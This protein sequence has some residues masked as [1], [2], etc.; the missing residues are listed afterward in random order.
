MDS[1]AGD[2]VGV[3]ALPDRLPPFEVAAALVR[4]GGD[5]ALL[6]RLIV[7][8]GERFA[9]A[10][11]ELRRLT[12]AGDW[13]GAERLVHSVRGGAA[14]I[15]ARALASAAEAVERACRARRAAELPALIDAFAARLDAALAAALT[16]PR[17]APAAAP[18]PSGE[19]ATALIGE[20]R[21][22]LGANN[23][24]ARA[25]FAGLRAAL[26]GTGQDAALA[27]LAAC[28]DRLEFAEALR[29]L[30]DLSADVGERERAG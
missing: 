19:S 3:E 11:D 6:R 2:A 5:R 4:L 26:A 27:R 16:L 18:A 14:Q 28:I 8:F 9:A 17:A 29:R 7:G 30:D 1:Q 12:G 20:L 25:C 21:R 22:L 15:E 13:S 24:R 10:A 23:L